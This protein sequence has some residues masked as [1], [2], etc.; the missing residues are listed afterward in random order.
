MRHW[1]S[2]ETLWPFEKDHLLSNGGMP[3]ERG[4][5]Q[6]GLHGG[7]GDTVALIRKK[8]YIS[9]SLKLELQPSVA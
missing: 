8:R 7:E 4:P 5:T 3:I 1:A 2:L 9:S 6:V